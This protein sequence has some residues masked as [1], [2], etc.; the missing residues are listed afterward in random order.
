MNFFDLGAEVLAERDRSGLRGYT[1]DESRWKRHVSTAAFAMT[2]V[3]DIAAPV[4]R[5]WLRTMAD[6]KAMGS[7]PERTLSKPTISRCMSLV[8]V[9]FNEAVERD[10]IQANPCIGVKQKKR[11]DERDTIDK[12]AFLLWPEQCQIAACQNIPYEDRLMIA[13]AE[14]TGMRAAEM[15][16]LE[17][18]DVVADGNDPHIMIRFAGRDRRDRTKKLTTKSGKKREVPLLPYALDA[19]R[20]WLSILP[21]YAPENPEGVVFPTRTGAL[22]QSGKFFGRSDTLRNYYRAAGITLRPYLHH[23]ALRHTFATNL[24]SGVYGRMW[25]T[26]EIRVLLGHSS[27]QITERYSHLGE[28]AIRRAARETTVAQRAS[29]SVPDAPDTTPDLASTDW[30]PDTQ[31]ELCA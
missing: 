22:R 5:E 18:G 25:R 24:I 6:K 3:N 11:V 28:D 27:V 21:L 8:S 2:D 17:T 10:I 16:H 30:A 1:R 29:M 7:G 12:W 14:H 20:E 31:R 9:I 13:V 15:I 26:E 19:M 4:L 23:H